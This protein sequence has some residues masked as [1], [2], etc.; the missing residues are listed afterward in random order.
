MFEMKINEFRIL[1]DG[2]M[3]VRYEV[4]EVMDECDRIF[5]DTYQLVSMF[6]SLAVVMCGVYWHIRTDT[7]YR[8]SRTTKRHAFS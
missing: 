7:Y 4:R 5:A 2:G 1:V 3:V 6:E 8:F